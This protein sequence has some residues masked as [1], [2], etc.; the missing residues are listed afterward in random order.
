MIGSVDTLKNQEECSSDATLGTPSVQTEITPNKE[1]NAVKPNNKGLRRWKSL[2]N[3]P[4]LK[5]P[6]VVKETDQFENSMFFE[7]NN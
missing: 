4:R 5:N 2:W 3:I 1:E 6:K 7:N